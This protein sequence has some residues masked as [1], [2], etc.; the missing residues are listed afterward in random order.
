[1]LFSR[2][3]LT[4]LLA[5]MAVGVIGSPVKSNAGNIVS[6]CTGPSYED[7]NHCHHE[8]FVEGQCFDLADG[9]YNDAVTYITTGYNTCT[10]FK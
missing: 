4:A 5:V 2:N 7:E 10:L 9:V 6:Y 3:H 1:M 8:D